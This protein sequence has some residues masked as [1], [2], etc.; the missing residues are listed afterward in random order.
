M[1]MLHSK[2]QKIG[3][4]GGTGLLSDWYVLV[5]TSTVPVVLTLRATGACSGARKASF[6]MSYW[7]SR[8]PELNFA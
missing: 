2:A 6:A 3:T 1:L 5:G 8:G 4:V 7:F